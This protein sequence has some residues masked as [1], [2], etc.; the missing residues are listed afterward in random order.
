MATRSRY[1][2][3]NSSISLLL[4]GIAIFGVICLLYVTNLGIGTSPDSAAYVASARNLTSGK[5]MTIP[6]AGG[7]DVPMNFRA[8]LYPLILAS[9]KFIG[10]EVMEGARWLNAVLFGGNILLMGTIIERYYHKSSLF[11]LL[12]ASLILAS[13]PFLEIH[14]FA[15][16]E[17]L[18]ILTGFSGLLML[19]MYLESFKTHYLITAVILVG[20]SWI[21]RYAGAP[22]VAVGMLALLWLEKEKWQIRIRDGLL[23]GFGASIPFFIWSLS[24]IL[25]GNSATG[26]EIAFHPISIQ[27]GWQAIYTMT[28]WLHIPDSVPGIARIAIIIFFGALWLVILFVPDPPPGRLTPSA[29]Q[30]RF[31]EIPD[32]IKILAIFVGI[33]FAFLTL[34][35]SFLDANTPL[36]NRILT[37]VYFA[38]VILA[39]FG[40]DRLWVLL[41]NR[42]L[43]KWIIVILLGTFTLTGLWNAADW[44]NWGRHNGLG[45]SGRVWQ[46]SLLRLEIE[47]VSFDKTLF[48]NSPEA[49]YFLSGRSANSLPKKVEATTQRTNENYQEELLAIGENYGEDVVVIFFKDINTRNGPSREELI[50]VLGL[51]P[52]SETGD[53]V[54]LAL[55]K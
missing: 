39:I 34:S 54:V 36:D 53:G 16:T 43:A 10:L 12:G 52:V 41:G 47:D 22:F 20:L 31:K 46:E 49:V 37:P 9:L 27:H 48:S 35:I 2:L 29:I 11:I 18:F 42:L 44:L 28:G 50:Q 5:G 8:P 19:V 26:R 15:W 30:N 14:A 24:Q 3:R 7:P 21:T 38:S 40:I 4:I 55:G 13:T 51:S 17:P 33:Y 32:I 25:S 23:F 6:S 45:F 1:M